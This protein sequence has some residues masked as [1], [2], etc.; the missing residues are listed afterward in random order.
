MQVRASYKLGE[1]RGRHR[2]QAGVV[3]QYT[4]AVSPRQARQVRQ[5]VNLA[6][7]AITEDLVELNRQVEQKSSK[8]LQNNFSTCSSARAITSVI[9]IFLEEGRQTRS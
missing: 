3:Q 1:W 2:H 8:I 5:V 7:V 9:L 4:A 6:T